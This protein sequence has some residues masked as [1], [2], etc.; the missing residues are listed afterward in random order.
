[1]RRKAL[2]VGLV[3]VVL[4]A[5]AAIPASTQVTSRGAGP[6]D[7]RAGDNL[8]IV[9]LVNRLE[10]STA[11]METLRATI[12]G[13][14]D[15]R[16]V[17]E[18]KRSDFERE[19]I[20]F[21]GTAEELDVRIAAYDATMTEARKG[22]RSKA[23][24]AVD[25]L[26]ETL[27]MKQGEILRQEIPGLL[28]NLDAVSM[29]G[30]RA[31]ATA[32]RPASALSEP[33]DTRT[34]RIGNATI[35]VGNGHVVF[36]TPD[37]ALS[38]AQGTAVGPMGRLGLRAG[39]AGAAP[40]DEA[41]PAAPKAGAMIGKLRDRLASRLGQAEGKALGPC[42][43]CPM[44]AVPTPPAGV[45]GGAQSSS[46]AAGAVPSGD[47]GPLTLSLAAPQLDEGLSAGEPRFV[48]WLERLLDVLELKLAAMP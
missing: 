2:R 29:R 45:V 33:G 44:T 14:L 25:T 48:L 7:A 1:M 43:G 31:E 3:L 9:L 27:T 46:D 36:A 41:S 34:L 23:A 32:K 35:T 15:E 22:F 24:D 47:F 12:Q 6:A 26:K 20:A 21:R 13:L 16:A 11:Q 38:E 37:P 30:A 18:S 17:L 19:M 39:P 42:P 5:L 4:G 40:S 28:G 10:L 8:A